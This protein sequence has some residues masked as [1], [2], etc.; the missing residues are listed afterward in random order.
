MLNLGWKENAMF[1]A[2]WH[3]YSSTCNA[4]DKE[5]KHI[6]CCSVDVRVIYQVC[7][8]YAIDRSLFSSRR[9]E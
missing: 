4:V 2:E 6:K 5:L 8:D 3:E 1:K 7:M 9:R